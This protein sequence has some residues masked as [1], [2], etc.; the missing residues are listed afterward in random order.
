MIYKINSKN[1]GTQSRYYKIIILNN[2]FIKH[3]LNFLYDA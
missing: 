1:Y 2:T 3:N